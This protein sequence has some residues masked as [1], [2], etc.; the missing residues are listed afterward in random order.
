MTL[1]LINVIDP[2][3]Y[4][5]TALVLMNE[6]LTEFF[7]EAAGFDADIEIIDRK[8][9][10]PLSKPQI[11]FQIAGGDGHKKGGVDTV[12]L[13]PVRGETKALTWSFRITTDDATGGALKLSRYVGRLDYAFRKAGYHL[14]KKGLS[15]NIL[16]APIPA[17]TEEF[18]QVLLTLT[19]ELLLTWEVA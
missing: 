14:G 8:L 15:K 4:V 12:G 3:N 19:N 6:F 7:N 11:F 10:N 2:D 17:H 16:S 9:N 18:Y 1:P 5:E 13:N